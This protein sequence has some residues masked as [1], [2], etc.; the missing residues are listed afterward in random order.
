MKMSESSRDKDKKPYDNN[1]L[2][3]WEDSSKQAILAMGNIGDGLGKITGATEK[4]G[5]EINNSVGTQIET[6]MRRL[7]DSLADMGKALLP[8]VESVT[9]GIEDLTKFIS[10]LNPEV[11]KS[12][13][14]F[15]AMAL[16]FGAVTK[17]TGSLV[18]GISKGASG[19]LKFMSAM[20]K[21][22][23]LGGFAKA[24]GAATSSTTR[25]VSALGALS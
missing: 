12:I 15:G 13:A 23:S 5:E 3:M 18:T 17:A 19:L 16:A 24:I 6:V 4:A 8:A 1:N 20:D 14:K 25:L 7:K 11:V 21:V 9:E 10:K 2:T 22:K